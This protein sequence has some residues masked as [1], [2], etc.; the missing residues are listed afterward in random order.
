MILVIV[1]FLLRPDAQDKFERALEEMQELIKQYDGYLGEEP[2][3][4]MSNVDKFVT[5][6]R[7]RDR[8]AAEAWRNDEKHLLVQALG[9]REVFSWYRITVADVEREY[10]FEATV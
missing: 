7:F 10:E 1:E 8:D 6:F 9:K 3:R 5:L 2:C 4:A